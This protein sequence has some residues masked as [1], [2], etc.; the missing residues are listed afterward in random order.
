MEKSNSLQT[1]ARRTFIIRKPHKTIHTIHEANSDNLIKV[2]QDNC[3]DSALLDWILKIYF[4]KLYHN[5]EKISFGSN[6]APHSQ[7]PVQLWIPGHHWQQWWRPWKHY[8]NQI[9]YFQHLILPPVNS[10]TIHV[11]RTTKS[12]LKWNYN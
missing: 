8:A 4:C 11:T 5:R 3:T 10:T 1:Y 6:P 7:M 9:L 12:K 2:F